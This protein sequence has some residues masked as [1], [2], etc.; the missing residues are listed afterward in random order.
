MGCDCGSCEDCFELVKSVLLCQLSYAGSLTSELA[1]K[2]VEPKPTF[3]LFMAKA[4]AM[5]AVY[6]SLPKSYEALR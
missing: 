2:I 4:E 3:K 6:L 1:Q 5:R